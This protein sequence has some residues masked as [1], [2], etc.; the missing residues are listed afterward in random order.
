MRA[1][2]PTGGERL[3]INET[4]GGGVG[5]LVTLYHYV[6]LS[7]S[8]F[9][10]PTARAGC[11][12]VMSLFF[13]FFFSLFFSP[14]LLILSLGFFPCGRW[15]IVMLSVVAFQSSFM[16]VLHLNGVFEFSTIYQTRIKLQLCSRRILS[17]SLPCYYLY[18]ASSIL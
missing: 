5:S 9:F 3:Y 15:Y 17:L 14:L 12:W 1:S 13:F 8:L 4:A 2:R 11:F 18:Y 10:V 6:F 7:F 16:R